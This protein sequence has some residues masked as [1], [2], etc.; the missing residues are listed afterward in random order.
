MDQRMR[1]HSPTE[2]MRAMSHEV[3]DQ[4]GGPEAVALLMRK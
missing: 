2:L 1:V 4:D 3:L